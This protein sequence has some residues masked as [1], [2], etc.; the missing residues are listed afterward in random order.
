MALPTRRWGVGVVVG[1]DAVAIA[2]PDDRP[3]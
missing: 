1:V 3:Q 2:S